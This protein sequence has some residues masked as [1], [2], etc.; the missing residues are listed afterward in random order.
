[1]TQLPSPG[2]ATAEAR[3]LPVPEAVAPT[4]AGLPRRE[5]RDWLADRG[6]GGPRRGAAAWPRSEHVERARGRSRP[7][8]DDAGDRACGGSWR[9]VMAELPTGTVTLLFTDVEGSTQLWE[10]AFWARPAA[11]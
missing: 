11:L 6:A 1:M 9:R 3:R 8:C 5:R 7:R 4:R 2:R 10:R